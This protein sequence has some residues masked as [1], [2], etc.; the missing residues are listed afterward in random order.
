MRIPKRA[1]RCC[2]ARRESNVVLPSSNSSRTQRSPICWRK[3]RSSSVVAFAFRRCASLM[4]AASYSSIVLARLCANSGRALVARADFSKRR[5]SRSM[6]FLC[7]SELKSHC[8]LHQARVVGRPDGGG[9]RRV[10]IHHGQLEVTVVHDVEYLP[11][12]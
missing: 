11:P 8:H 5:R 4:L 12:E 6:F 7:C 9:V 2:M 10:H 1:Q 3:S